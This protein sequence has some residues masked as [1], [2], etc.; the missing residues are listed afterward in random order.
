MTAGDVN[1]AFEGITRYFVALKNLKTDNADLKFLCTLTIDT[2][3]V[4]PLHLLGGMIRASRASGTRSSLPTTKT[5]PTSHGQTGSGSS[6]RR[7]EWTEVFRRVQKFTFD[8]WL[9]WGPSIPNSISTNQRPPL[10]FSPVRLRRREQLDRECRGPGEIERDVRRD[11]A[12][13]NVERLASSLR[14]AG[15]GPRADRPQHHLPGR[16]EGG[17]C[18]AQVVGYRRQRRARTEE[19]TNPVARRREG[20][21]RKPP[22]QQRVLLRLYLGHVG[23]HAEGQTWAV[24]AAPR[25]SRDGSNPASRARS[26][27]VLRAL[28][29][30]L[31][32]RAALDQA[33][34]RPQ[35]AREPPARRRHRQGG[36]RPLSAA[37]CLCLRH[38]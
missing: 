21:H 34:A 29:H 16:P 3:F 37:L 1:N 26:A 19:G 27:A 7:R 5:W 6:P 12:E 24:A 20:L 11:V 2:G 10:H 9:Q 30:R 23:R 22:P 38:R 4:S 13:R 28:Q 32:R 35:G 14:R 15:E 31:S 25:R 17:P 18:P 36:S 33:A 8:C